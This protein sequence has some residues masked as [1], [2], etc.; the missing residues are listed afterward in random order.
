MATLF[1]KEPIEAEVEEITPGDAAIALP[2]GEEA[3]RE[4]GE[5]AEGSH[6]PSRALALTDVIAPRSSPGDALTLSCAYTEEN[7]AV[8]LATTPEIRST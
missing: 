1:D 4:E 6:E 7:A 2:N 5:E 8:I 3:F